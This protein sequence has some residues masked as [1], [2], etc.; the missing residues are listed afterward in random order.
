VRGVVACG[1][2]GEG[3][4]TGTGGGLT[5]VVEMLDEPVLE[6]R[7][8]FGAEVAFLPPDE[9]QPISLVLYGDA[10]CGTLPCDERMG[11]LLRS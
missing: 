7:Q 4:A 9:T 11:I 8:R 2:E 5:W 3:A 10:C 1:T 6:R